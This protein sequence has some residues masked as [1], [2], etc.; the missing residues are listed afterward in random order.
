MTRTFADLTESE[1][2]ESEHLAESINNRS[3]E[4]DG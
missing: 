1:N 2:V 4:R 3:L